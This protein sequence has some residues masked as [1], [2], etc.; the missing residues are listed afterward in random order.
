M[1][2]VTDALA[3]SLGKLQQRSTMV[4]PRKPPKRKELVLRHVGKKRTKC[5][6][7]QTQ[8]RSARLSDIE[9][10]QDVAAA[11]AAISDPL[12]YHLTLWVALP[13]WC[14]D[15][16]LIQRGLVKAVGEWSLRS[17]RKL[18][19]DQV[20]TAELIAV[21]VMGELHQADACKDCE[22]VGRVIEKGKET[23]CES[24]GGSGRV[25]EGQRKRASRLRMS[26]ARYMKTN[27]CAGYE[28][29]WRFAQ[30]RLASALSQLQTERAG[31][32][33]VDPD[34]GD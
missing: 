18:P 3:D 33:P 1:T 12:A 7:S 10:A 9:T 27:A 8:T 21:G 4:E 15:V 2:A 24:C 17:G 23:V 20:K 5:G 34:E 13:W 19:D 14:V 28:A 30:G 31:D 29:C 22:G 32:R 6:A 26:H 25:V 11:L 16:V